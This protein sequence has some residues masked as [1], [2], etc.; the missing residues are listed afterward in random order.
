[1]PPARLLFY[2][3]TLG[4]IGLSVYA[5]AVAPP[6]PWVAVTCLVAYIGLVVSGV[7]FSRFSMFADVVT[8]GPRNARG[9]ALTFDDGPDPETTPAILDLLEEAGVPATFFLIGKKAEAHPELVADIAARGHAI[10][11]HSYHHRRTMSFQPPWHVK[12]ELERCMD[13][14][15]TIT[16]ERPFLYRAPIGHVSPSMARVCRELGLVVVGWSVRG[17]DGWAGAKAE[18]VANRIVRG[19]HDGAIALLHDAAERGDFRPASIDALPTVLAALEREQLPAV[20]VDAW[21]GAGTVEERSA[22]HESAA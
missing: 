22:A 18:A 21:L 5:I 10:G 8:E 19:L 9:V 14:L 17:V 13:L 6:P 2:L 16:G 3:A 20:R 11:I 12:P 1:M 7:T 15:E 4:G